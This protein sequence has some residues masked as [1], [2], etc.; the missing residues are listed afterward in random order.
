MPPPPLPSKAKAK[1]K[2]RRG[3]DDYHPFDPVSPSDFSCRGPPSPAMGVSAIIS[4]H[5]SRQQHPGH[6]A[7]A[8]RAQYH[9]FGPEDFAP[10]PGSRAVRQQQQQEDEERRRLE[11]HKSYRHSRDYHMFQPLAYQQA[12]PQ[13]APPGTALGYHG[14]E[15]VP[16]SHFS[17]NYHPMPQP[18]QPF[19]NYQ[20]MAGY[21]GYANYPP[22]NYPPLAPMQ[23]FQL[24]PPSSSVPP[25]G[26]TMDR[27]QLEHNLGRLISEDSSG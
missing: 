20:P 27:R 16:P 10:D 21:P 8:K 25:P 3:A 2:S 17:A 18:Q 13:P 1:A 9:E 4:D 15:F 12:D 19:P 14:F 5:R 11:Q 22:A 23:Q 26:H 7:R 24:P 6:G